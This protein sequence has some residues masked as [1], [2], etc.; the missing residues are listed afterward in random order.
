MNHKI[1]IWQCT[2]CN[3]IKISNSRQHHQMDFC[4]CDKT[5]VDLEEYLT[6]ISGP[7]TFKQ[8]KKLDL[9]RIDIF[10]ELLLNCLEQGFYIELDKKYIELTTFFELEK[11][12]KEILLDLV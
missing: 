5:G 10:S 4:K 8:L 7:N 1:I 12:E 2:E 11:I 6:R 9:K 3:D